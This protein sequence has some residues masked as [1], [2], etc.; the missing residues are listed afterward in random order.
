MNIPGASPR[1]SPQGLA[2]DSAGN[3]FAALSAQCIL[4]RLDAVTGVVT[5]VAGNG[6]C[7]YSGDGASRQRRIK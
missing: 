6:T 4:V 3:L 1:I 7:G 5:L 2:V